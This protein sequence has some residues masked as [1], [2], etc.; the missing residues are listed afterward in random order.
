[1]L[2]PVTAMC[3]PPSALKTL[4]SHI[5]VTSLI[6]T[7]LDAFFKMSTSGNNHHDHELP[8]TKTSKHHL[9][10]IIIIAA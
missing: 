10:I 2:D 3:L 4:H 1:M 9:I 8:S 7:V 5:L 6:T